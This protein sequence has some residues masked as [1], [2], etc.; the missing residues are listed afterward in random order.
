MKKQSPRWQV[1]IES[2]YGYHA[3]FDCQTEGEAKRWH[4]EAIRD[5]N[6]AQYYRLAPADKPW[7]KR[8]V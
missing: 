3:W 1:E 8:L 4:G 2:E 6:R 5:G 7:I